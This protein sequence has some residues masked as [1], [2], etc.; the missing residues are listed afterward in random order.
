M[1]LSRNTSSLCKV[2][3]AQLYICRVLAMSTKWQTAVVLPVPLSPYEATQQ[4][5]VKLEI[6]TQT[7]SSISTI[8][9]N[10]HILWSANYIVPQLP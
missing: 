10:V 9:S 2:K 8:Q 1:K 5:D 4:I 6:C 3:I 7:T